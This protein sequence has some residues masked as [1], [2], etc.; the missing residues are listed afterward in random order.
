MVRS[1]TPMLNAIREQEADTLRNLTPAPH[2]WDNHKSRRFA[3]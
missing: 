2:P 3:S 1:Q